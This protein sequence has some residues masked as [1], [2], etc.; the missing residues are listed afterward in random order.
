MN[1]KKKSFVELNDAYG[2]FWA[3]FLFYELFLLKNM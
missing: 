1:T 3:P 2:L